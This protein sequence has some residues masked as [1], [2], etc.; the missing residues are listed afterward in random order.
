KRWP[1]PLRALATKSMAR[2]KAAPLRQAL[3]K[4]FTTAPPAS[5]LTAHRILSPPLR[6]SCRHR[7][8][9]GKRE[10]DSHF[11]SFLAAAS[12]RSDAD[13]VVVSLEHHDGTISTARS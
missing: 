9:A 13:V 1:P 11:L 3:A 7:N 2:I 5:L 8:L 6:H 10:L 12:F 4:P